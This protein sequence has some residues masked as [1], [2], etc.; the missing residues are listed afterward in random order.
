ME[1]LVYDHDRW[2]VPSSLLH[3]LGCSSDGNGLFHNSRESVA[4]LAHYID[5]LP[6]Y[7]VI[8]YVCLCDLSLLMCISQIGLSGRLSVQALIVLFN[9]SFMLFD[10]TGA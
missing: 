1:L 8:I 10:H 6:V 9:I 5:L 7:G 2:W 3:I 4:S